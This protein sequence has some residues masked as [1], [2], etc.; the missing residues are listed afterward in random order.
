MFSHKFHTASDPQQHATYVRVYL[1]AK[2]TSFMGCII[3]NVIRDYCIDT[4]YQGILD[5]LPKAL[6]TVMSK[7]K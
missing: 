2:I 5:P 1:F 4:V 6:F 3:T 7:K